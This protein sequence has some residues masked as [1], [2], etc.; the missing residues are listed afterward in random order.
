MP[1]EVRPDGQRRED[2]ISLSGKVGYTTAR[3]VVFDA[4]LRDRLLGCVPALRRH[5]HSSRPIAALIDRQAQP[6]SGS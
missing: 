4:V 5:A 6:P 3:L 1:F 2:L